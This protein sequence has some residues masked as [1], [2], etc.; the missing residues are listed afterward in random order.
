MEEPVASQQPAFQKRRDYLGAI[1]RSLGRAADSA[2]IAAA[3][4]AN[5]IIVIRIVS[6]ITVAIV[7]VISD[8]AWIVA[9]IEAVT[10]VAAAMVMAMTMTARKPRAAATESPTTAHCSVCAAKS[11]AAVVAVASSHC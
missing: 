4:I 5:D 1:C 11:A 2:M 10:S 6:I 7:I 3:V 8:V 9:W